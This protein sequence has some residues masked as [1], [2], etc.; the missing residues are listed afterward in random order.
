MSSKKSGKP[1]PNRS[2]TPQGSRGPNVNPR[3]RNEQEVDQNLDKRE[4]ARKNAKP[5]SPRESMKG[6]DER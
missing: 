4:A 6:P 1:G 2:E 5:R 3:G